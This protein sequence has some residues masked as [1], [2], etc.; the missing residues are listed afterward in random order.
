MVGARLIHELPQLRQESR[1]AL[2]GLRAGT[3]VVRVAGRPTD[4]LLAFVVRRPNDTFRNAAR[5]PQSSV[6]CNSVYSS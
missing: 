2:G 6:Y 5:I 4:A 1:D 3:H